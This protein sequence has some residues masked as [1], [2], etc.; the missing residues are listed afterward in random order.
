MMLPMQP[1]IK[2]LTQDCF[3]KQ[4]KGVLDT[5]KLQASHFRR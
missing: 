5:D 2:H 1:Q 4:L 3:G